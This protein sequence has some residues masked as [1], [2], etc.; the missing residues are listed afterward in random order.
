M[1][2]DELAG[3]YVVLWVSHKEKLESHRDLP[4]PHRKS[5]EQIRRT[6]DFECYD[7]MIRIRLKQASMNTE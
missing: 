1:E 4:V 2:A 5:M 3:W 7:D 6:R